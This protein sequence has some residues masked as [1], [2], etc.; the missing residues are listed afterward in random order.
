[1]YMSCNWALFAVFLDIWKNEVIF[2][3]L[4]CGFVSVFC[5]EFMNDKM[6]VTLGVPLE[7]F[8]FFVL[9]QRKSEYYGGESAQ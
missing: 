2:P 5:W 6:D 1:M 3:F 4:G 8:V 7:F 9:L